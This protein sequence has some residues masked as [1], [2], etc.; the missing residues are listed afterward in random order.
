MLRAI[1]VFS[2]LIPGI[3]WAMTS[4]FRAL[5]MYLW[6]AFFRPQEWVWFSIQQYRFSV[7][8]GIILVIPALLTGV[9]PNV[10]HPLSIGAILFFAT[11][12]IAQ[13]N[14]V[15]PAQGWYWI[16]LHG[17]LTVVCLLSISIIKTTRQLMQVIAV[18]AGC[19]AFFSAKAGFMSLLAGGVQYSEGLE[20]AFTDNNSYAIGTV[21]T[22]PLIVAVAQNVK[23]TFGTFMP[24]A[25]LPWVR[26]GLLA[27]VP[28]SVYTIV[29]T[30]SRSGF[31]SLIAA[32]LT[33][34]MF[35][36][37]RVRLLLTLALL[38]SLVFVV[39]LPRGYADR[40][41]TIQRLEE[42]VET[43]EAGG[44]T[45]GRFYFWGVALRMVRD[46]PLGIGMRNYGS[47][48]N[49]YD[50][51]G[52]FGARRDV[53]SSHFQVLVEHGYPGAVIWVFML[54]YTVLIA[55]RV[56]RRSRTPG[57][58]AEDSQ[59]MHTLSLAIIVSTAGFVV[60]GSTVSIALNDLTW[61]TFALAASLDI[62]SRKLCAEAVRPRVPE[63]ISP[64][65][66]GTGPRVI[67]ARPAV[68]KWSSR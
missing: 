31:L 68:R 22:I 65:G 34:V 58:G 51:V 59:L 17:T 5:L 8:L 57:L 43:P 13:N 36:P 33:Y 62:I 50:T 21:M 10:T 61:L 46:Y 27:S 56:R 24:A 44:V 63:V 12:L 29:S 41:A 49:S 4:R 38:G 14:A 16:D 32:V 37:K 7:I 19:M 47:L 1:F 52:Y 40:I 6:F 11:G 35:H 42:D 55:Y 28:F 2:I 53:H 64:T 66:V 30:F 60:G 3:F 23:L 25:L 9:F 15:N 45:A 67:G 26:G 39:P 18:A 54:G 48:Y 20:G